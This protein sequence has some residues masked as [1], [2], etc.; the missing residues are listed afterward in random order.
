VIPPFINTR[1]EHGIVSFAPF[2][3]GRVMLYISERADVDDS[4]PMDFGEL[5][6]AFRRVVGADAPVE[7][8]ETPGMMRRIVGGNTRL[9]ERYRAGRVLLV[10]DAAHVHSPAGGQGM[11]TGITDAVVLGE[12]LDAVLGGAPDARLDEYGASRRP[13]ALQ[14]IE[15]ADRLT[16]LATV[17]RWARPVRNLLLRA[18]AT[19]PAVRRTLALRLSGLVYRTR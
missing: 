8:L 15:L 4:Q 5:R 3:D 10:G 17:P 1:T 18:L 11:N 12:A 2:P 9:A 13:V 14:V 16:R 7:E 19:V 6:A